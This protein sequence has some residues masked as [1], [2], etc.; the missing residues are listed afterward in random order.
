MEL[1]SFSPF[2][3]KGILRPFP[4]NLDIILHYYKGRLIEYITTLRCFTIGQSTSKA[5]KRIKDPVQRIS[6]VV[7]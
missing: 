5:M 2:S 1:P 7:K 6:L 3:L 4:I